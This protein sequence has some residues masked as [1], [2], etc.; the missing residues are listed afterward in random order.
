MFAGLIFLHLVALHTT[1]RRLTKL[2]YSFK[3]KTNYTSLL[4]FIYAVID[5]FGK[6]DKQIFHPKL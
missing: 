2:N 5:N 3:D 6:F 1:H 4:N